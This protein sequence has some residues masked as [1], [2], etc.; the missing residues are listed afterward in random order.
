M[1][2]VSDIEGLTV[3]GGAKE[4]L[5][6]R[7]NHVLFHPTEP[8]AIGI[9]LQ[10]PAIGMVVERKPRYL[11]LD[12]VEWSKDGL[13]LKAP[14]MESNAAAAKRLGIDWDVSVIWRFMGVVT[15][16]G[17]VLGLARDVRFDPADGRITKLRL[18]RGATSDVAIGAAT[19]DGTLVLGFDG[20]DVRVADAASQVDAGGGVARQAGRGAA[21]AKIA[22]EE[23]AKQAIGG[24]VNI[25]RAV[26]KA[27]VTK[28]AARGWKA[29]KD[30]FLEGLNEDENK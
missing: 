10:P 7:V 23:T 17:E 16:S 5:L 15:E 8:R 2:Y 1:P 21:I 29:M 28:K 13:R 27:N 12:A 26:S 14:K 18:T 24:A 11:A 4:K 30:S 19:L 20:E 22:A 25:A 9:E 6:G 3:I